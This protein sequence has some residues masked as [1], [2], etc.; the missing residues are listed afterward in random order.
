M[1]LEIKHADC[2]PPCKCQAAHAHVEQPQEVNNCFDTTL[3]LKDTSRTAEPRELHPLLS[4]LISVHTALC[5]CVCAPRQNAMAGTKLVIRDP[6][7]A[8]PLPLPLLWLSPE[9]TRRLDSWMHQELSP[10]Q[11]KFSLRP[12]K[13]SSVRQPVVRVQ[14]NCSGDGNGGEGA[15]DICDGSHS[16]ER[17]CCCQRKPR[18]PATTV[19]RHARS[20]TNGQPITGGR[21]WDTFTHC[22]RTV[23]LV[24][25]S[26]V[27]GDQV[28]GYRIDHNFMICVQNTKPVLMQ[29]I[30]QC[31]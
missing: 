13:L 20:G 18:P 29:P 28:W 26:D 15:C 17:L 30:T 27:N 12:P 14:W 19:K 8:R 4:P 10:C 9:T 16:N 1:D 23:P 5:L 24:L 7:L 6:L 3:I 31:V 22:G 11:R 2:S 21:T 25:R